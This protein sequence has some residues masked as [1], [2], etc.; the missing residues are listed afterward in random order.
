M[1]ACD[2]A[3]RRG[4]CRRL[5]PIAWLCAE[6]EAEDQSRRLAGSMA[7]RPLDAD[8]AMPTRPWP[9]LS[10][11]TPLLRRPRHGSPMAGLLGGVGAG[12]EWIKSE[13]SSR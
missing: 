11:M 3:E 10:L 5:K 1:N 2:L 4:H 6:G 8:G 12:V 9:K 7:V 13:A